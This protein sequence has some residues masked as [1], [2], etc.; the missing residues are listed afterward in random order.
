MRSAQLHS[1]TGYSRR[2][3]TFGTLVERL[4]FPV[5]YS[6]S[7]FSAVAGSVDESARA[8]FSV[9]LRSNLPQ[10]DGLGAE[11]FSFRDCLI[12]TINGFVCFAIIPPGD[13][14]RGNSIAASVS[15]KRTLVGPHAKNVYIL[16][17][18]LTVF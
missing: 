10:I 1:F 3:P 17:V 2:R 7:P 16:V 13:D 11:D 8:R 14:S 6:R 5:A 12:S 18:A 4:K 15:R 9:V